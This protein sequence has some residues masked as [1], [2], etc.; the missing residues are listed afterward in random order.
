MLGESYQN[1]KEPLTNHD[2]PASITLQMHAT[3]RISQAAT[4]GNLVTVY[5]N[6]YYY[7][8]TFAMQR[9]Y[10]LYANDTNYQSVL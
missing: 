1:F 9:Y 8:N 7:S 6:R 5:V 4:I 2:K 10:L 3:T